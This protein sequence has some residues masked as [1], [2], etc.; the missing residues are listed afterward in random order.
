MPHIHLVGK[1]CPTCDQPIP[2]DRFDEIKGRIEARQSERETRITSRL[3]EE[4]GRQKAEAVEQARREA[5]ATIAAQVASAREE[6]RRAAGAAANQ[7]LAET[8]RANKIALATM[9]TRIEQAETAKSDAQ[10]QIDQ[11][12]RDN[13]EIIQ[14][15]NQ[16][17]ETKETAIHEEAQ[18][19]AKAGVQEKLAGME[20][21]RQESEAALRARVKEA[22]DAKVAAQQ[23]TTALQDQ[24]NQVRTDGATAIEKAEQDADARVN[25]ARQEV[26]AAA[27]SKA[28]AAEEAAGVLKETHES[29][30]EAR[31]SE[32]RLAMEA[33]KL[34]AVNA[35]NAARSEDNRKMSEQLADMQRK[36]DQKT[37]EQLGEGAEADLYEDL[38][39]RFESEGDKIERVGKGKPGA[40]VIHTVKRNGMVCGKIIYD[41][42]NH[43]Q[44]RYDFAE[45]LA[46]DKIAEKA[47][48][49]ILS[50]RKF[51]EGMKQLDVMDG[52]IL[53]NPARVVA[54]VQVVREHI[55][56][57]HTLRISNEEKTLKSAE[58]Y[59][60]ITSTQYTDLLDRIDTQ[61]QELLDVR[62]TEQKVHEKMW[63]D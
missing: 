50:T 63:K 51:P 42:K 31:V 44:W 28:A 61:A 37:A 53:A 10:A 5:A 58:L 21:S 54:L 2:H 33:D 43:G 48:H 36:L 6:A 38:K 18:K 15:M 11:V 9:Q 16:D 34:Q 55:V 59:A 23:S 20:R 25:A 47:D 32:V 39:A 27:E 49:A 57:S 14:Q 45:K 19:Q 3:T 52:V 22:E 35:A 17:A 46:A 62:V 1:V 24:L 30:T 40:D 26:T 12:R 41:S 4:F 8:E 56:K 7:K 13:T 60:F 29:K